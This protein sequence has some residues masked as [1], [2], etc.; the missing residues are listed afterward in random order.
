[1]KIFDQRPDEQ[2]TARMEEIRSA[3]VR[4]LGD[5][6]GR[7]Q[8]TSASTEDPRASGVSPHASGEAHVEAHVTDPNPAPGDKKVTLLERTI[9]ETVEPLVAA[10]L[11][12]HLPHIVER[13]VREEVV[14]ISRRND[15]LSR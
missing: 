15:D 6:D 10:W 2:V 5:L 13:I 9:M 11:D 14:R 12:R 1:M 7:S 4:A 8:A 3:V